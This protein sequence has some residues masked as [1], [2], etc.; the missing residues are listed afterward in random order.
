MTRTPILLVGAGGHARACIDVIELE[1]H[2]EVAGLLG[3]P[4]E[5][6]R[7]VLGYSVLGCNEDLPHIAVRIGCALVAV[8]Q[9]K[10]PQLRMDLFGQLE[11]VGCALPSI[12]SPRGYVSRHSRLG[13]GTIVLHGAIVN[14]NV[15]IGRN[16]IVNSLALIEHDSEVADHCHIATSAAVN[17]GV[18]VG[19]GT[20]IGS[21]VTVRQGLRIGER[22]VIGM[23]QR[24][25]RD[26]PDGETIPRVSVA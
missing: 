20:F 12:V 16:C 11:K 26:C 7:H 9:I 19:A 4:E 14:S 8:G 15:T 5:V 13:A 2:F 22:C 6:G 1:G 23:G 18:R 17:S 21:G 24:V 3:A 25:L 10:S